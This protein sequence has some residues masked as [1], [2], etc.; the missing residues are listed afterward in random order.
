MVSSLTDKQT[1]ARVKLCVVGLHDFSALRKLSCITI[2][3]DFFS[4]G[5]KIEDFLIQ[6]ICM[7]H[8][9]WTR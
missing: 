1:L 7:L 8:Q 5:L 3:D 2:L 9:F 4:Y 6:T